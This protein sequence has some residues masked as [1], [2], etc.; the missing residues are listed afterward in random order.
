LE[1]VFSHVLGIITATDELIFF[2]GVG[3]TTNQ[4]SLDEDMVDMVCLIRGPPE[5]PSFLASDE[6]I[7]RALGVP[8]TNPAAD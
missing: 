7:P 8:G 5:V 3:Y 2:R 1:H 4:P 6:F